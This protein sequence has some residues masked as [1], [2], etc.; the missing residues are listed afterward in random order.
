MFFKSTLK[1]SSKLRFPIISNFESQLVE[2]TV[3][4]S[5]KEYNRTAIFNI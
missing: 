3:L 4:N 5:R 1:H 2:F